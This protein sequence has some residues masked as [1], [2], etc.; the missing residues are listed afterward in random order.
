M[1]LALPLAAVLLAPVLATPAGLQNRPPA[2]ASS[3]PAASAPSDVRARV[4]SYLGSIDT[5]VRPEEWR[6]LGPEGARVLEEIAQDP[7]KLPTRRARA[8]TALGIV[9]SPRAAKL[10]V[11]LAQKE[12]EKAVVRMSAVRAAGQLLDAGAL[13]AAVKPV[14]EGARDAHVRAAAAAVLAQRNPKAG[15]PSVRTQSAREK[16]DAKPAFARA[17]AACDSAV[18]KPSDPTR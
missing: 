6:A 3:A 7:K 1:A 10:I 14:L 11:G 17:L 13:V 16:Q 15:C 2:P 4:E 5:P 18:G 12:S 9:G 8:V